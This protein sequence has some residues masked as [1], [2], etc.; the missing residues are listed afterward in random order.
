LVARWPIRPLLL[1]RHTDAHRSTI[2]LHPSVVLERLNGMTADV[3]LL[4]LAVILWITLL[5]TIAP[6]A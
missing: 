6:E 1:L 3:P 2:V 4:I 5:G